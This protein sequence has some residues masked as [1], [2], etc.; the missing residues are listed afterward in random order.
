MYSY[1]RVPQT[2]NQIHL[3]SYVFNIL[4]HDN[5]SVDPCYSAFSSLV[6]AGLNTPTL[7]IT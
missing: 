6:L 3:Q 4:V 7:Q 5:F 1:N 2:P